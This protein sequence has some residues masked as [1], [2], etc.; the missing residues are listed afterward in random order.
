[1]R[2]LP[3]IRAADVTVLQ[4][5]TAR[6]EGYVVR[7]MQVDTERPS[8]EWFLMPGAKKAEAED[9][10][11][12]TFTR[13]IPRRNPHSDPGYEEASEKALKRWQGDAYRLQ[14]Y[15]YELRNLVTDVSGQRRLHPTEQLKLMGFNSNHLEV[16][17]KLSNDQKAQMIGNSFSAIA[18][19]RLLACLVVTKIQAETLDLTSL[20]WQSW[21]EWE[22]RAEHDERP[23]K[24]RFGS[25]A[26][27]LCRVQTLREKVLGLVAEESAIDPPGWMNGEEILT[28]L[29]TRS[30]SHK[31]ATLHLLVTASL[32]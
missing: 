12:A 1:M 26:G 25:K 19:A 18:V 17:S 24:L 13:P 5:H 3:V 20:L 31:G 10:P 28:Y 8:L 29:M 30:A 27:S 22:A 16:K 9:Q 11:F 7:K 2:N 32:V 4:N 15:Q 21:Y 6:N 14:P 23:W